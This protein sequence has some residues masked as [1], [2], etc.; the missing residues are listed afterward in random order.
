MPRISEKRN[1]HEIDASGKVL[2]RLA[3]EIARL[4]IG[5][6]KADYRPNADMGDTVRVK[7]ASAIVLTGDKMNQKVYHHYSQYPGGMKTRKVRDQMAKNPGWV[8]RSA[9]DRMLPKNTLRARRLKRLM[10]VK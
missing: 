2:G 8:I 4:L 9:V 5:K 3:T 7:N 6:H 10:I 1:V